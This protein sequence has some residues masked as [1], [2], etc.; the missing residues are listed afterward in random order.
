MDMVHRE[1]FMTPAQKPSVRYCGSFIAASMATS[2][3]LVSHAANARIR[4]EPKMGVRAVFSDNVAATS[5]DKDAGMLAIFEPGIGITVD[6]GRT[7]ATLDYRLDYRQPIFATGPGDKLRHNL[8]ARGETEVISDFFWMTGGATVTQ[9][10]RDRQ[11]SLTL[12]P[13]T[14]SNNLDNVASGYLEPIIRTRVNDF[15]NFGAGFRYSITEVKDRPDNKLLLNDLSQNFSPENFAFQPASD[16]DGQTA[17][18]Q[19]DAGDYFQNFKWSVRANYEREKRQYLNELYSSKS[20][21]GDL[22]IPLSRAISVLGSAGWEE[23]KDVQDVIVTECDGR[24]RLI[25]PVTR[26]L[27]NDGVTGILD[28]D[29][30]FEARNGLLA[31]FTNCGAGQPVISRSGVV[32]NRNGFIWDAGL[33]LSPGRKLNLVVRGGARFG[34][35]NINGSGS[36]QFSEKTILDFGYTTGI[37]SLGRLLTSS[38]SGLSPQYRSVGNSVRPTLLPQF[39]QDPL[40]GQIFTGTLAINSATYL[41]RTAQV[42]LKHE[43]GPWSGDITLVREQRTLQSIQQLQGQAFVDV[44]TIPDDVTLGGNLRVERKMARQRSVYL[45]ASVQNSKFAL[46]DGRNDWL[47][48]GALGYRIE[49]TPKIRGEARYLFSRRSSSLAS[50]NL[51]ENAI[52]IGLEARF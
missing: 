34:D 48:G 33:R 39:G 29:R 10:F 11:G 5:G 4:L 35:I 8:A 28:I 44:N 26:A 19:L 13:D 37:D 14:L 38:I 45:E 41:S 51:S 7:Q 46:S 49:F 24:P 42:R 27:T 21:I 52:S 30:S 16:S 25:D 9:L 47:Y 32:F 20:V 17:Y 12:N 1:S 6:S 23:S 15:A 2:L 36:Y 50:S 3:L 31:P 18:V 22:E 43:R 40:T